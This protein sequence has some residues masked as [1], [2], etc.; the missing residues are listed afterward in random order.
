[1]NNQCAKPGCGGKIEDGYCDQCG[2]AG[3]KTSSK[4]SAPTT[5]QAAPNQCVKP[6]CGGKIED[7]YCDQCG[8]AGSKTLTPQDN[9]LSDRLP[10][11]VMTTRPTGSSRT[12]SGLATGMT[13]RS[14]QGT[15]RTTS[16]SSRSSRRQRLGG[17]LV[18]VPDL[19]STEPE[20]L[21][22][23]DPK[24]PDSKR[25]CGNCDNSLKRD[26][27]FCGKC[28]QKYSFTPSL[29]PGDLVVGQ[30]DV[31]GAIAY[32]GLGWIYLAYDQMLNRYVVL[33]GLLNT[34]DAS[35]AAVAV[36]ER[37]FLASVKHPNIVGIY[38]FVNHLGEG[39][40]VMEYVGG[41]TLKDIRKN[42]GALPPAEAI[43]YIHRVLRAFGYLHNQGLVYCDFKPDN[44]LLESGDIKLIDLG[45]VRR[46]DDPDGDIY[47]TVG[48][49]APEAGE[50]PTAPSDLFTIGRT[51]A[52][53]MINIPGFSRENRYTLP[54]AE[55]EPLFRQYE[56]LHRFLLKATAQNPDDRFQLADEMAEQLMGVL[57]EV[58]SIDTQTPHPAGSTLFT[59]DRMA[60]IPKGDTES[61]GLDVTQ[62]PTLK[63]MAG[64]PALSDL[65]ST[66]G[67]PQ[68]SNRLKILEH[69]AKCHPASKEAQLRLAET[70]IEL[71]NFAAVEKP[72]KIVSQ[73]DPW[74]WRVF[75]YRGLAYLKQKEPKQALEQF[76]AV[77]DELPGEIAPKLAIALAAEQVGKKAMAINFYRLV[78]ATDP[79]YSSALFGL[80]RCHAHQQDRPAAQTALA[81]I[82][83]DS[84]LFD[85]A[86]IE[87]AR[88][89]MGSDW[90]VPT[91]QDLKTAEIA[92]AKLKLEGMERYILNKQLIESAL[93][94][95]VQQ[96]IP[97]SADRL[98][99]QPFEEV[100][101]RTELEKVL[102]RMAHLS[103]GPKKIALVDEANGI[104]PKTMF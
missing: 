95:L 13:G 57:R 37:Q 50:G 4:T 2:M 76:S 58:V 88:L 85:R 56:S 81:Q 41:T 100:K 98:L 46:I 82:S 14:T 77:Y 74:E 39:F 103:E 93:A 53:L 83:Q 23:D 64:D 30:Y 40:I 67:I 21:V 1:M 34:E 28:G 32:G 47:G 9:L 78:S 31:K 55:A 8:M 62:L 17:G 11:G 52:V 3:S 45:G 43:A 91:L 72:L 38:N 101:L 70:Q 60:L 29:K 80:G 68:A 89:M 44:I 18:A 10:S 54:D 69:I 22:L 97:P 20:T 86:K 48:Y 6:G 19:P 92:L 71:D 12:G 36:A 61:I 102:R 94:L 33:K 16:T 96:K 90:Q 49:S 51:L 99:G 104:R 84:S 63:L 27:G 59:G 79:S 66:I 73:I 42:R 7:G 15:R 25:I 87:T 5:R 35:S 75:W 24:V 26:K 65:S